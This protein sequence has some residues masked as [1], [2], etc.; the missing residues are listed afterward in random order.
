MVEGNIGDLLC[1]KRGGF[2]QGGGLCSLGSASRL[3][4]SV[5]FEATG[6]VE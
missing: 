5:T 4:V 6:L 3:A 1:F 2:A